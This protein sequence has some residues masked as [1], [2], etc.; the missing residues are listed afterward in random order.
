MDRKIKTIMVPD[1]S[2]DAAGSVYRNGP[3]SA[4][5]EY[6]RKRSGYLRREAEYITEYQI[7]DPSR[8]GNKPGYGSNI[9]VPDWQMLDRF[10][11]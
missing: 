1:S 7:S 3:A 5:S 10:D 2:D 6:V 9:Y 11:K 8:Q 4:R